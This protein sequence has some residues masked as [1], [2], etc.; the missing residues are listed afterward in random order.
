MKVKRMTDD[1]DLE[2]HR[3]WIGYVQPVG[4]LVAPSALVARGIVPDRN[5]M[6][7][8]RRLQDLIE[9]DEDDRDRADASDQ[10]VRTTRNAASHTRLRL[11]RIRTR[12]LRASRL[13]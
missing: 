2:A 5:I 6:H 3:E 10:R 13:F 11:Y 12:R 4:L 7:C 1:Y 9:R 8:Q